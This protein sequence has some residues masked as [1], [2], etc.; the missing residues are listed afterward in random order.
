MH[1]ALSETVRVSVAPLDV[2]SGGKGR[3]HHQMSLVGEEGV[4]ISER[5]EVLYLFHDACDISTP[6]VKRHTPVKTLS[7]RKF[8]GGR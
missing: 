4:G 6:P 8:V 1:A 7:S 2:A 3:Y 5:G